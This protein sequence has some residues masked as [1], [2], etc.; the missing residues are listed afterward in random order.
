MNKQE[1]LALHARGRDAWNVWAK[2][3]SAELRRLVDADLWQ[4]ESHQGDDTLTNPHGQRWIRDSAADFSYHQFSEN[5][6]FINAF[7][8]I[9]TFLLPR[10]IGNDSHWA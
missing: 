6:D 1:S 9:S 5:P 10:Q 7:I 8:N 2:T 3:M 4:W